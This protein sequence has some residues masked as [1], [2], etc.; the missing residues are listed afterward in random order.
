MAKLSAQML[1]MLDDVRSGLGTHGTA[2]HAGE[3][4]GR[5]RTA[6]ALRA[7][8]LL[9]FDNGLTRAGADALQA[10]YE[11]LRAAQQS[12]GEQQL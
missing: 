5:Y 3:H 4:A 11:S 6:S 2:E 8:G 12:K 7:R 10:A 9:N 1:R